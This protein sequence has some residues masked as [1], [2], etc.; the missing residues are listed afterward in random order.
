MH[1]LLLLL[2]AATT[3]PC[4]PARACYVYPCPPFAA[5]RRVHGCLTCPRAALPVRSL[6]AP[7]YVLDGHGAPK[8]RNALAAAAPAAGRA[9]VHVVHV[10]RVCARAHTHTNTH[11]INVHACAFLRTHAHT[12]HTITIIIII[13]HTHTCMHAHAQAPHT[14]K[15]Q[16]CTVSG[17]APPPRHWP[18][19]YAV[20]AFRR[21]A[22]HSTRTC[23]PRFLGR[24]TRVAASCNWHHFGAPSVRRP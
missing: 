2:A 21:I 1:P 20:C 7:W 3:P 5:H 18:P 6:P 11:A 9:C 22:T 8:N 4:I 24:A 19:P 13:T 23:L 17:L 16:G 15:K 10:V 12:T 14:V